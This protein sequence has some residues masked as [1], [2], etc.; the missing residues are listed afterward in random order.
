VADEELLVGALVVVVVVVGVD[1]TGEEDTVP[2]S[3]V[4]DEEV[5]DEVDDED[6]DDDEG[7]VEAV[8]TR[9]AVP[10]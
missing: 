10:P 4:D 7:F 5:D 9:T 1:A 2:V 3:P 6:D 8:G